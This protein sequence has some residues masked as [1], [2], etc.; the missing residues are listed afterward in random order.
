MRSFMIAAAMF[1]VSATSALATPVPEI[2][3]SAGVTAMGAVG[4]IFALV[5]ERRRRKR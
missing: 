1:M 4:A 3:A 2:D 5:L